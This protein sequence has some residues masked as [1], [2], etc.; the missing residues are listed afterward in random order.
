MIARL[1]V[2]A[3]AALQIVSAAAQIVE[4]P[5]FPKSIT[6]IVGFAP[7]G[8]DEAGLASRRTGASALLPQPGYDHTARLYAR[9]L[10]RF[11]PGAV[12]VDL[13]HMPG[14]GSARAAAHLY[15]EAPTDGSEI[16]ILSGSLLRLA[17]LGHAS[18]PFDPRQFS[19]IGGRYEDEYLCVSSRQGPQ[20]IAAING[21]SIFGATAPGQRSQ[22]HFSALMVATGKSARLVPGYRDFNDA[23]RALQRGEV[24]A[25]CGW[26]HEDIRSRMPGAGQL[27]PIVRFSAPGGQ[28]RL[29]N[30]PDVMAL[31]GDS[32]K[33]AALAFLGWEGVA[34]YTLLAPP[35]VPAATLEIL[36]AGYGKMMMDPAVR[37]EGLRR[38]LAIEAVPASRIEQAL[39]A[40]AESPPQVRTL[41]ENFARPQF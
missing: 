29:P 4:P 21:E 23:V 30:V 25:L 38:N 31:T 37:Q 26:S 12:H 22:V 39:A 40:M 10:A 36:R 15:T 6:I 34:A 33:R 20:D 32:T 2:M 16:A 41:I 24:Q 13:R 5:A 11:L 27:V 18:A 3:L 1:V 17:A 7:G 9:H 35:G 28:T 19:V 14:A 8:G